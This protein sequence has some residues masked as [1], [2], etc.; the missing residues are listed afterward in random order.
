M[1]KKKYKSNEHI[2]DEGMSD[3][4][5]GLEYYED[6][7]EDEDVDGLSDNNNWNYWLG[8]ESDNVDGGSARLRKI[9]KRWTE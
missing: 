4:D 6:L 1:N 5:E 7:I 9:G 3:C 8:I 2:E